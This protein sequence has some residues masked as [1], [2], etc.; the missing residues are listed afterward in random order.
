MQSSISQID[1]AHSL[2]D[3]FTVY[4]PDRRGRGLSGPFRTDHSVQTEIDDLAAVLAGTGARQAFGV[5][6][7]GIVCL[8][9]ALDR[10]DLDRIAVFEPPLFRDPAQ[11]RAVLARFDRE[12]A[13]GRLPAAMVTGMLGARMGPAVFRF[14]PRRLLERLTVLGLRQDDRNASD[15]YIPMRALAPA[16]HCD[17]RVV[18]DV[19]GTLETLRAVRSEVLLLGGRRSPA[20]LRAALGELATILPRARRVEFPDLNHMA[21]GNTAQR[22]R[23]ERVAAELRAFFA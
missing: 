16:L 22:G 20:Y 5:S 15:S 17:I 19:S 8:R 14:V 3:A 12:M 9:A 4:L 10:S 7:G 6:S 18:A 11:A 13:E 2:A 21:T 23:P 1:L